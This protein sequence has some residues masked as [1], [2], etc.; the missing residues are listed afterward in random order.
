M[1]IDFNLKIDIDKNAKDSKH[2]IEKA[3]G[4]K[5]GKTPKRFEKDLFFVEG[6]VD[7]KTP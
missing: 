4:K 2:V 3:M 6:M 7:R 5:V 1:G